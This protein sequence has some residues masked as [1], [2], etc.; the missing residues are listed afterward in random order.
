MNNQEKE[1]NKAAE[2]LK[3]VSL[4]AS[5]KNAMRKHIYETAG[6]GTA[7]KA[8]PSPFIY[9]SFF[10]QRTLVALTAV[11]LMTAS[12]SYAS[13]ASLA[14]LPGDPLYG[15]KVGILEP[16]GEAV[17]FKEEERNNYRINLL[18]ER[19]AEIERLKED[20]RLESYNEM[21]SSE[22]AQR[23]IANIESSSSFDVEA[24]NSELSTQVE[25][26]NAII[27]DEDFKLKTK[28]RVNLAKEK[29]E[30]DISTT[31]SKDTMILTTPEVEEALEE[32]EDTV[33]ELTKPTKET[34]S[35][36]TEEV[37]KELEEVVEKVVPIEVPKLIDLGL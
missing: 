15:M 20:G 23:T 33:E 16:I 35:P 30:N 27:L 18:R 17:H 13:F 8:I 14:S 25:T 10:K 11:F 37:T 29:Q 32:L 31:S 12:S 2:I 9:S 5:E 34:V 22:A 21:V 19:V 7:T 26:Y 1:F 24:E 6:R 28:L 36:V 4:S 3:G